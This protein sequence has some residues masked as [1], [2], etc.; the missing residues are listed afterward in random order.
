MLAGL[1]IVPLVSVF[2]KA[3][4]K[5]VTDNAFACYERKV[6][7]SQKESIGEPVND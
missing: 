6:M 7:V 1:V 5:S 4:D 2:T 3:P